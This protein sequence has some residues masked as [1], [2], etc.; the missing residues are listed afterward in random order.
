MVSTHHTRLRAHSTD[1]IDL[2]GALAGG[3]Q[4]RSSRNTTAVAKPWCSRLSTAMVL[5][6]LGASPSDD[7][8]EKSRGDYDDRRS[9]SRRGTRTTEL[10]GAGTGRRTWPCDAIRSRGFVTRLRSLSEAQRFIATSIPLVASINGTCRIPL[11]ETNGHLLVI[12][13][14]DTE[15]RC[16]PNDPPR[17]ER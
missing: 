6:R 7:E 2:Q 1:A 14:F 11:R 17:R 8:L 3:A 10:Q 16:D 12:R 5:G 13:G 15:R 9:T 4:G